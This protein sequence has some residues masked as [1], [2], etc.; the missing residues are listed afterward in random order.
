[1]DG[2]IKTESVPLTLRAVPSGKPAFL[3]R[4]GINAGRVLVL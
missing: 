2:M 3:Y 1:M 4:N